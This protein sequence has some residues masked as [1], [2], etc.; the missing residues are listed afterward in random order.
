[1]GFPSPRR[2][3]RLPSQYE[4][5]F[6]RS[7]PVQSVNPDEKPAITE[8]TP[9]AVL[10][11]WLGPLR[12]A[13]DTSRKNW[14]EGMLRWR[15]GPFARSAEDQHALR[16]QRKWCEQMHREGTDRFFRDPVWDTP[17]G[18]LAKLIVL[19]QFPRS[20]YRGTA[21]AYANDAVT[22]AMAVQACKAGRDIAQYNIVERF[23]IYV[24][25]AHAEDLTVQELSMERFGR[26]SAD[27]IAEA[28]PERRRTN[29]FVG[30]SIIKGV[31]EHSEAL[32]LFGRFPHRNAAMQRPHRGG[33]PRY[34][35]DAMRPLWSFTQPPNPDYFALL[36]ALFRMEDG[37]DTNR[38]TREA[39]A[40]LL[41]AAGLSPEDPASPMG[42]FDLAGSD[43]VSWPLL[44]RHLLLPEQARTLDI[45]R[46]MPLAADL[47]ASVKRLFLKNGASLSAEELVWPPRSARHSVE[48]AIDVAALNALV[49]GDGR[50]RRQTNFRGQAGRTARSTVTNRPSTGLRD[51]PE[52]SA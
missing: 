24:P 51:P 11:F 46:E 52:A 23:W 38:I 5:P 18:W 41:R 31:I 9:E 1:M 28:P 49:H 30:W 45:L 16:A 32:L 39:L 15:M 13:A 27:L 14:Q 33:E 10:D 4:T 42:V 21:L 2:C 26:W 37:L 48:P 36:G 35:A 3:A 50:A 6:L 40:G 47:T 12:T 8:R 44:Y 7:R 22:A 17:T 19:D 25:L 20:V 34:L 43:A 29:Q